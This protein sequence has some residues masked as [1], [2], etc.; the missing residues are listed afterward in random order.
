[1]SQSPLLLLARLGALGVVLGFLRGKSL[2]G[3]GEDDEVALGHG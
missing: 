3:M 1:M 2:C